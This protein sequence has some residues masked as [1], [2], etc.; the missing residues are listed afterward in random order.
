VLVRDDGAGFE[1]GTVSGGFGLIG[2]RERVALVG[3]R[4]AIESSP[5][6]GTT[7]RAELPIIQRPFKVSG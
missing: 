6:T 3:G 7:V 4:L 2:M 5:G 1:S